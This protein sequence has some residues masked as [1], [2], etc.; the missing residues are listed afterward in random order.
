MSI[1]SGRKAERSRL[2]DQEVV[3]LGRGDTDVAE[4][5]SDEHGEDEDDDD[6]KEGGSDAVQDA[7]EVS[8]VVRRHDERSSLANEGELGRLGDEGEGLTALRSA[9]V[10]AE[11][12]EEER[13][14]GIRRKEEEGK[15]RRSAQ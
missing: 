5:A 1:G 11:K 7:L 14:G 3:L 2:T 13:G 12:G 4:E 10:E 6:D 8:F 15:E 9:G